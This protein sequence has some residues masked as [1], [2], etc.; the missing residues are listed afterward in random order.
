[1]K[2]RRRRTNATAK[3]LRVRYTELLRLREDVQRLSVSCQETAEPEPHRAPAAF[4]QQ[5]DPDD[6][7]VPGRHFVSNVLAC[8][9]R[10]RDALPV[11]RVVC[12]NRERQTR[13]ARS[14]LRRFDKSRPRW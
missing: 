5:C 9:R 8:G 1:M 13:G 6:S 3:A 10:E 2:T 11:K 12:S 14:G 7:V 4:I